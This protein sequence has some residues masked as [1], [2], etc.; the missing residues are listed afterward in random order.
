[1][2]FEPLHLAAF[3]SGISDLPGIVDVRSA[4]QSARRCPVRLGFDVRAIGSTQSIT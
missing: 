1:M 3:A 2:L 4:G